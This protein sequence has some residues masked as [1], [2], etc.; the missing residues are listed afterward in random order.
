MSNSG[1]KI[2]V[3]E[4]DKISKLYGVVYFIFFVIFSGI[5]LLV[6]PGFFLNFFTVVSFLLLLGSANL[7]GRLGGMAFAFNKVV[8]QIDKSEKINDI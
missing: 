1:D 6:V 8:E 5:V 2:S 7:Y 3:A 4:L